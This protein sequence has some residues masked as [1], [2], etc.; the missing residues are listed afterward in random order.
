MIYLISYNFNTTYNLNDVHN[1]IVTAPGVTDWWHY[2]PN[3]YLI[4]TSKN[5]N[6]ISNYIMTRAPGL[7]FFITNVD[8]KEY[9]GVLNKDAWTW[10]SKKIQK[11]VNIK[12][13]RIV[14]P[15]VRSLTREYSPSAIEIAR[16][17]A[18]KLRE[19]S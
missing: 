14:S 12:P 1:L 15:A 11:K 9:H 17:L 18:K 13:I 5:I 6:E 3:V 10:I 7:L 2:L 4:D 16:L 19:N 8:F